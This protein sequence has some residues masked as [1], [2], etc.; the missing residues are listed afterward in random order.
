MGEEGGGMERGV[1]PKVGSVDDHGFEAP[2]TMIFFLFAQIR[3]RNPAYV[4]VLPPSL[5][6]PNGKL[7]LKFGL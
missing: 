1:I 2:C 7:C 3:S 4:G 6:S 5:P